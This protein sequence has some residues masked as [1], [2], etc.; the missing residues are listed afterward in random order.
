MKIKIKENSILEELAIDHDY[1]EKNFDNEDDI[2]EYI[3]ELINNED[4]IYYSNAMEF[5]TENDISLKESL[6]IAS[7]YGF[8]LKDLNSETLA[9]ILYQRKLQDAIE[10]D[11][12]FIDDET[13]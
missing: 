1:I 9:N 5:L 12:E 7:E 11:L 3:L 8:E 13:E 10:T 2:K 4:I 6:E